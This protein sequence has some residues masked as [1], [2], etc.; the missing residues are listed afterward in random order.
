MIIDHAHFLRR[1]RL[2]R[3]HL[4]HLYSLHIVG[5]GKGGK[6]QG[7]EEDY[8]VHLFHRILLRIQYIYK[9]YINFSENFKIAKI[10]EISK[11]L[12]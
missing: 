2:F 7:K 4:S 5:R 6:E 3:R 12:V 1:R 8:S 11:L 9:N 10:L